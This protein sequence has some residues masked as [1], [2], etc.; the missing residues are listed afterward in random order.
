MNDHL[1][2]SQVTQDENLSDLTHTFEVKRERQLI[3]SPFKGTERVLECMQVFN[4]TKKA[5]TICPIFYFSM[6]RY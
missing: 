5:F 6:D 2:K 1:A 4:K 3:E